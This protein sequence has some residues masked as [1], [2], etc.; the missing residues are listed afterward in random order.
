MKSVVLLSS[1]LDSTVNL[2]K[3]V[4]S[5]PV[6]LALTFDYSQRASEKEVACAQKITSKLK[7]P[8]R[9]LK[10]PFFA[11][12]G[13]SSLLDRAQ[14]VPSGS[15]VS[16]DDLSTSQ[17]TAKSVWVPNR[18][19]IF[20]NIA[21]GFAET[22]GADVVIPGFNIEEAATFPD[23][24]EGFLQALTHS[25]SFSTGNALKA[26]CYTTQ[27]SKPEIVKMGQELEVDWSQVWP[28]YHSGDQW[29]GQ[30]ESCLR[31]KRAFSEAQVPVRHLFKG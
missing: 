9:V 21:A 6:L 24:T 20:L 1:G 16:I 13:K 8:H 15:Q 31:A 5:G 12:F 7:V 17:K 25:F 2:Y 10:L 22:L 3:A 18:N 23:N 14:S 29:C 30:C 26:K 19:G 27:L 4:Q 11:E 28:C